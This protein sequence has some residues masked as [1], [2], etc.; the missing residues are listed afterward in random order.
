MCIRFF[1]W[2][3]FDSRKNITDIC[4]LGDL[5]Q[6]NEVVLFIYFFWPFKRA[7]FSFRFMWVIETFKRDLF[8]Y[9]VWCH[10]FNHRHTYYFDV[11]GVKLEIEHTRNTNQ[12]RRLNSRQAFNDVNVGCCNFCYY[13]IHAHTNKQTNRGRQPNRIDGCTSI[14]SIIP[15]PSIPSAMH[16]QHHRLSFAAQI[17]R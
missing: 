3:R 14:G 15:L 8:A 9:A 7:S 6:R 12:P 2:N 16:L 11:Y 5:G 17:K 4:V 1:T 13:Q 10:T